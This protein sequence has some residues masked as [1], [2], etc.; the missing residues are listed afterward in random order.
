VENKK[1]IHHVFA[2]EYGTGRVIWEADL[3]EGSTDYELFL[4]EGSCSLRNTST[5]VSG[6][7]GC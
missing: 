7:K 5:T 1:A 6:G 3:E 4:R 2:F